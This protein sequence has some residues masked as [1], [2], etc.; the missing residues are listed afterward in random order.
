[1]TREGLQNST[2]SLYSIGG[3]GIFV[4]IYNFSKI[5][6]RNYEIISSSK[7]HYYMKV[8]LHIDSVRNLPNRVDK[9]LGNH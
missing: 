3:L 2:C 1:M 7:Q 8:Y 4:S 6:I 5:I 9:Y